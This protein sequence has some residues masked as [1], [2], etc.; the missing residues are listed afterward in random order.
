M[1]IL[2]HEINTDIL[3]ANVD[4]KALELASVESKYHDSNGFLDDMIGFQIE[5]RVFGDDYGF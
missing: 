2:T 4:E 1:K 3:T 5:N